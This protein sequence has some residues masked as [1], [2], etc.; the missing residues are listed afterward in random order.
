[1]NVKVLGLSIILR[2]SGKK[3]RKEYLSFYLLNTIS[4]LQNSERQEKGFNSELFKIINIKSGE[5]MSSK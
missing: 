5:N 4:Q 2:V 3:G 1:M